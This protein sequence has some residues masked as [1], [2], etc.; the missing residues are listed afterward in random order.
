LIVIDLSGTPPS[1][2][3]AMNVL[4]SGICGQR[5]RQDFKKKT[6]ICVDEAGVFLRN[7]DLTEFLL[8]SLTMGRSL[9]VSLWCLSQ[10]PS[11]LKKAN[12]SEE[13]FTNMSM[14]IVLGL[15]MTA[16]NI[17]IVAEQF[18][19]GKHEREL[20]MT[21]GVGEGLFMLGSQIIP[22]KIQLTETELDIIKGRHSKQKYQPTASDNQL[23][24]RPILRDLV[25]EHN[26]CLDSWA[27]GFNLPGWKRQMCQN[28]ISGAGLTAAWI[29]ETIISPDGLVGNQ[30]LDHFA[31][32]CQLAAYI[33]EQG[34]NNVQISHFNDV[35]IAFSING[36]KYGIEYEVPG[37]HNGPELQ[38][39]RSRALK[40]YNQVYFVCAQ[41]YE[42]KLKK[43]VGEDSVFTRGA[44]IKTLI[45][46]LLN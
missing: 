5:F 19:L 24:I 25:A 38:E 9:G 22:L 35:D 2:R 41:K 44:Q 32:V 33:I 8:Q 26:F 30:S 4:V 1:I 20:L 17:G 13:F 37:S 46:S 15:N 12:V 16:D 6:V 34:G 42:Q 27:D 18:K 45:D 10:Q 29:R 11:D 43:Y 23:R 39:K 36:T 3:D 7:Q 14:K 28:A 40:K 21:S 31:T